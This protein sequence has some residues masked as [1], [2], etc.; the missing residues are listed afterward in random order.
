MEE[1][2]KVVEQL[3]ERGYMCSLIN[4][5]F[6]KPMDVD[7][8][9]KMAENHKLFVTIEEGIASGGY[10]EKVVNYVS[11]EN[12]PVNV[13]V[14]AIPDQYV[15]QGSIGLLRKEIQLDAESIVGK[16]VEAFDRINC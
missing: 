14:N 12:L 2:Y 11:K 8:L 3:C 16:I 13:L 4:V 9:N 5:R 10:G 15:E 7:V 1:A 6:V